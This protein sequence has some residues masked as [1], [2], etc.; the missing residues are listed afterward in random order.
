M[1]FIEKGLSRMRVTLKQIAEQVGVSI[2]TV[3][4]ALRNR[5]S[6]N[7][8]TRDQIWKVATELGY[9]KQKEENSDNAFNLC[10]I[11]TGARLRDSYF[12]MVFH[13]VILHHAQENGY[14]MMVLD[15][16]YFDMDID[17]LKR[18]FTSNL[19]CGILVL[20]DMEEH[21]AEQIVQCGLPVVAVGSRYQKFDVC[22]IIEDNC[23]AS[24]L[25]VQHLYE[26]GY[27]KIG[28]VGNPNHSCSFAERF[29]SYLGVMY[30][31]H[32]PVSRQHLLLDMSLEN[33]YDYDN[34]FGAIQ[35]LD[36]LPEAFVCANDYLGMV[37]AKALHG[38][39][40]SVPRD[41]ALVG[42]DNSA[43]GKLTIPS[44]TS[45]DVHC[46]KQAELSVQKLVSFVHGAPYEPYR[47]IVPTELVR[48]D[49]VIIK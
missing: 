8:D 33:L 12:Y 34:I 38:A 21:V 6:I 26:Q 17:K 2:N 32:L 10:L 42:I 20:G 31:L 44:L 11:S 49:S 9:I 13:Q 37:T 23:Q 16:D 4:L 25:A 28:F 40:F 18:H 27:Q 36:E 46:N 30:K 45:V 19:I 15:S 24:Y 1:Q 35:G 48:G 5:P 7:K 29:Q 3:S 22:T 41:V 39:K 47:I 43:M 14:N